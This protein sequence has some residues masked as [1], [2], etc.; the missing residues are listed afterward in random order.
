MSL[1]RIICKMKVHNES[2]QA[3]IRRVQSYSSEILDEVQFLD[4][5]THLILEVQDDADDAHM[6]GR[7]R[8]L[9]RPYMLYRLLD[10]CVRGEPRPIWRETMRRQIRQALDEYLGLQWKQK[11]TR[12]R[13]RRRLTV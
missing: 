9:G 11:R 2:A 6:K 8:H 3:A 5:V 10:E 4:D 7:V 1:S 13:K 12:K